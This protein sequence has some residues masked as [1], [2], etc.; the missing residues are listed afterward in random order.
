VP[1]HAAK[2]TDLN[3]L[4]DWGGIILSKWRQ[5]HRLVDA[6]VFL[7]NIDSFL[8]FVALKA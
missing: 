7:E 3:C 1:H 4:R 5:D 2:E 6:F 8:F